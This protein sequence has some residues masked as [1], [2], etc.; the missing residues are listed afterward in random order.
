[1][2][3]F[4]RLGINVR[5]VRLSDMKNEELPLILILCTGNSCRSQMGEVFLG[6]LL[7]GRA[8]VESA[9]SNPSGYVHPMA[10]E[11]MKESGFDL[12]GHR[13]KHLNEFF[14]GRCLWYYYGLW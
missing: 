1:M 11:V 7:K 13:S 14:R 10:I 3:Y 9:G 12:S 5:R 8:R 4:F 6:E 2:E